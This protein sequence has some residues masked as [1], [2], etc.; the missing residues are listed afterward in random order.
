MRI[1]S[2]LRYTVILLAVLCASCGTA[3][4]TIKPYKLDVQQGNVVTSK[5]LLQLRPGMTK[6][7]VRFI[8]G[9]PLIQDSFHGNRWDYVYQMRE[10]GKITE[11]RRVI[12]DFEGDSLKAVR[13]DVIP[14]GS[15]PKTDEGSTN[16][17]TR[18]INPTEKPE[19]KG[20]LNKLKFWQKD[21]ATLAKEAAAAKA[22][23]EAEE[24]AK[25]A[26]E[27]AKDEL[28]RKS[29]TPI[30]EPKSDEPQS[31]MAVPLEALP[32]NVPTAAS[33]P[34]EAPAAVAEVPPVVEPV[35]EVVPVQS[36]PV[37]EMKAVP[38]KKAVVTQTKAEPVKTVTE[39]V[40]SYESAAGMK[41][42]RG[43]KLTEDAEL[44]AAPAPAAPRAGNKSVPKPKDLPPEG[45]PSFF[46]R[47]LEKIGF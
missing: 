15:E 11:Q 39:P 33:T 5:M 31:M 30:E 34:V 3:L 29:A 40:K 2:T 22:K 41:F 26:A 35:K 43:M 7:Q 32:M 27:Q 17:G 9:T 37:V 25:S 19:E 45:E 47:M 38:E 4:P 46:D 24:A 44:E 16:S 14:K 1:F 8:M 6:S 13:G 10:K 18:V 12:L 23:A 36:S 28:A 42:D 20:V 21:E